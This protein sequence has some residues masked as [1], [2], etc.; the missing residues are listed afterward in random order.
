[1]KLRWSNTQTAAVE[2]S[3]TR[4]DAFE[5]DLEDAM[6]EYRSAAEAAERDRCRCIT[7]RR[8]LGGR[9]QAMR[10]DGAAWHSH[11][12]YDTL[13]EALAR[14]YVPPEW[15]VE[16]TA[17]DL[18]AAQLADMRDR[19]QTA[20]RQRFAGQPADCLEL[21]VET[22]PGRWEQ[23]LFPPAPGAKPI[24][25]PATH[26]VD[27]F[28]LGRRTHVIQSDRPLSGGARARGDVREVHGAGYHDAAEPTLCGLYWN[29]WVLKIG[30]GH[31]HA[32]AVY[33]AC[34]A[35]IAASN[36]FMGF[37]ADVV[38]SVTDGRGQHA[39]DR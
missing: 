22:A 11:L 1:M 39:D 32:L 20:E 8:T 13:D 19:R 29:D 2:F 4:R 27:T 16:A 12:T 18:T 21:H 38:E 30:P 23:P 25:M 34:M 6:I 35:A 24:R 9:V 33:Q 10:S 5:R 26:G 36:R 28:R 14:T 3:D 37:V 17:H 15:T 31:W 7:F